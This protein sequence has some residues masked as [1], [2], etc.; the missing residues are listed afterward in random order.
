MHTIRYIVGDEIFFPTLKELATDPKFT[1]DNLIS[2]DDVE[3]LFTKASGMYLKPV[4]DLYLRTT[5]KLD[6]R[7]KQTGNDEYLIQ[8]LNFKDPLPL[9]VQTADGRERRIVDAKGITVK[10]G[11]TPVIDPDVY[12]LKRVILE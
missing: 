3:K 7:V 6:V 10:S 11:S 8:L 12:Y 9:D 2:T 4:F 5:Q 1:Y